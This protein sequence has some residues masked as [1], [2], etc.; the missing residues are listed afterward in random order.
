M[1]RYF[2]LTLCILSLLF[3]GQ[4]ALSQERPD[5]VKGYF[6]EAKNSYIEVVSGE[7][8]NLEEAKTKAIQQ[9]IARRSL[10]TGT[11]AKVTLKGGNIEVSD[12]HDLI[13][14]ARILDEWSET[15]YS[16][17]QKVY[18]LVQTAKNPTY[19]MEPV[20]VSEKYPFS[21]KV[22]VPGL[23]QIDKGSIAKGSIII[24]S[25]VLCVGGIV[26]SECMRVKN[27]D[28]I[29]NTK[30]A[31]HKKYYNDIANNWT[32]SRNSFIVGAAA[33][34]LWNI[35]DGAVAKG[36]KHILIGSAGLRISPYADL[37]SG[38]LALNLNF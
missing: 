28:K 15:T 23:A 17:M 3:A 19:N 38:G 22:F 2:T 16:N 21:W 12:H 31:D 35:I 36:K 20:T 9:V 29:N 14:S 30:N 25:E 34:Y 5:W 37:H 32:I 8:Y 6:E 26:I 7:A 13:I 18:L 33:V 27:L 24:G 4:N 1:M 11:S 10:T